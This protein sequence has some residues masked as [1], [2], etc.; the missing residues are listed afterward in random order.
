MA[1]RNE[2]L[3]VILG[4]NPPTKEVLLMR[5]RKPIEGYARLIRHAEFP[6]TVECGDGIPMDIDIKRGGVAAWIQFKDKETIRK[7]GQMLI[8][9][10]DDVQIK[11]D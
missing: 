7:F 3:P 4:M 10:A 8:D 5:T 11:E 6:E 2:V 1:R 9:F